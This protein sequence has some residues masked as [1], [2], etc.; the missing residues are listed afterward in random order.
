MTAAF[1][2]PDNDN[3]NVNLT[4]L[5]DRYIA[6]TELP[7][8]MEFDGETLGTVGPVDWD[9]RVGGA[10]GS[11]H[12][13]HDREAD[14]LISYVVDFSARNSYKL[15]AVP[16]GSSTRRLIASIPAGREPSYLHSIA[17]T[18]RYLVLV[19]GRGGGPAAD[20]PQ[21]RRV[22]GQH[23][24]EAREGHDA[25]TSSTATAASS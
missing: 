25:S 8:P 17:M 4:R 9:D 10:V 11:A 19:A 20:H 21:G 24:L 13:H 14:E 16:A 5:G 23:A 3:A 2:P 22:H 12:P 1:S 18:E 7:V 15:F 6:M